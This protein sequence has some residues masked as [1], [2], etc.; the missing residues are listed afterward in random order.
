[1]IVGVLILSIN[2]VNILYF[3]DPKQFLCFFC[4][5]ILWFHDLLMIWMKMSGRAGVHSTF[6]AR[7]CVCVCACVRAC[8][9]VCSPPPPPSPP[10]AA[11]VIP[12]DLHPLD[13]SFQG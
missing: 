9:C 2:A 11:I 13:G 12:Q 7:V 10:S 3:L 6:E 1:M 4:R 5:L 8:A